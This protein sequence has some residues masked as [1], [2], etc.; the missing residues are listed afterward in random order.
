MRLQSR[1]Y[2]LNALGRYDEALASYDCAI[3]LQPNSLAAHQQS[4]QY[5][6]RDAPL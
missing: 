2:S 5:L 4:R 6:A 1:H 3:A